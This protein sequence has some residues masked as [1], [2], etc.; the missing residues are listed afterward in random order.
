MTSNSAFNNGASLLINNMTISGVNG[1]SG[2]LNI[3][4]AVTIAT[5]NNVG[6]GIT[7]IYPLDVNGAIRT[8]NGLGS[9]TPAGILLFQ[10][11]SYNITNGT[12]S[13]ILYVYNPGMYFLSA[14]TPG[15]SWQFQTFAIFKTGGGNLSF[16]GNTAYGSA[17]AWNFVAG[18]PGAIVLYNN[19]GSTQNFSLG[20]T[21]VANAPIA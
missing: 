16:A 13:Y 8:V 15:G 11:A 1:Y 18:N 12:T 4:T 19:T 3:N 7:P 20:I 14:V 10:N 2:I 5:N 9:T 17:P 6:I 21:L